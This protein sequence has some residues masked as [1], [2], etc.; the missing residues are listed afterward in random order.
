VDSRNGGA[1]RGGQAS[2]PEDTSNKDFVKGALASL[3]MLD[4]KVER[5]GARLEQIETRVR[6]LGEKKKEVR[7]KRRIQ[8]GDN[9]G[10]QRSER[11]RPKLAGGGQ[12]GKGC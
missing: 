6:E 9:G 8:E 7:K 12:L 1:P 11:L 3:D 5:V 2:T 4:D 10:P